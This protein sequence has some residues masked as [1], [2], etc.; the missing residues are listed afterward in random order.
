MHELGESSE[1]NNAGQTDAPI[2]DRG[3][4]GALCALTP[5]DPKGL[6]ATGEEAAI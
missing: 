6:A 1:T 3:G 4:L 2:G 5:V